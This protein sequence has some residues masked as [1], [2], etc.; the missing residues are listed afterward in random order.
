MGTTTLNLPFNFERQGGEDGVYYVRKKAWIKGVSRLQKST[1]QRETE[2][3]L[4]VAWTLYREYMADAEAGRLTNI[5]PSQSGEIG[6]LGKSW[7]KSSGKDA[8]DSETGRGYRSNIKTLEAHFPNGI[9]SVTTK[10]GIAFRDCRMG[11]VCRNSVVKELRILRSLLAFAQEKG[12]IASIPG[13]PS[14]PKGKKGT[15]TGQGRKAPPLLAQDVEDILALIPKAAAR[16]KF[17]LQAL[18]TLL[19]ET[20]LRPLLWLRVRPS[21]HL[22]KKGVLHITEDI[23]KNKWERDIPLSRRAQAAIKAVLVWTEKQNR[24]PSGLL[25]PNGKGKPHAHVPLTSGTTGANILKDA[26]LVAIGDETKAEDAQASMFRSARITHWEIYGTE[27]E[28]GPMPKMTLMYM[29]GHKSIN[30]S[31]DYNRMQL[32]HVSHLFTPKRAAN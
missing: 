29:V 15:P 19:W 5:A 27:E 25:F 3:A 13:I 16:S 6:E 28:P 32:A 17:P 22:R 30:T 7:L 26:T 9:R 18:C 10:A 11:E 1:G 21:V 24:N 31:N 20:G 4:R 23:D 8:R 2:A 12:L 14:P